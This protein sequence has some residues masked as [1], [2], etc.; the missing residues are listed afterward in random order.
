MKAQKWSFSTHTSA[1]ADTGDYDSYVQFTNGKDI[2]QTSGDEL[3]EE[4]LQQF[5]DLLDCMP[6]LWSHKNDANEFE[7]SQLKKQVEY[8]KSALEKISNPIKSMEQELKEGETLNGQYAIQ[9]SNDASYLKS[10]ALNAINDLDNMF[11]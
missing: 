1:L 10:I 5:C 6:D 11:F 4:Q 7:N 3:E 9:L 2:L 8:L